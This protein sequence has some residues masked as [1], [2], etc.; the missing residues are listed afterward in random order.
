MSFPIRLLGILIALLIAVPTTVGQP[1]RNLDQAIDVQRNVK[2][3]YQELIAAMHQVARDLEDKDPDTAAAIATAADKAE[4]A[5][6]A[7]DMEKVITLLESGLVLP[8]DATQAKVITQLREV[9]DVLRRGGDDLAARFFELEQ[10]RQQIEALEQLLQQQRLLERK[11][12]AVAFGGDMLKNIA[13][14]RSNVN[15][16]VAAVDKTVRQ[17]TD[18]E[19][20]PVAEQLAGVGDMLRALQRQLTAVQKS[21][22]N[23]FPS[24]DEMAG[25]IVMLKHAFREATRVRTAIRTVTNRDATAASL[26]DAGGTSHAAQV[27][28]HVDHVADELQRAAEALEADKLENGQVAVAEA[29]THLQDASAAHLEV[30]RSLG[31]SRSMV[32]AIERLQAMQKQIET[33]AAQVQTIAP[34]DAVEDDA[35]AGV[36]T[37]HEE[38]VAADTRLDQQP[39]ELALAEA[40]LAALQR[41]DRLAAAAEMRR[42]SAGM[43]AWRDRLDDVEQQVAD[44]R[45]T[46]RFDEQQAEQS[47]IVSGIG[48]IVDKAATGGAD[49][50]TMPN[51]IALKL[52][53]AKHKADEAATRLG[54]KEAAEANGRQNE[55][56]AILAD[57]TAQMESLFDSQVPQLNEDVR[58]QYLA[59]LERC[60]LLQ[61]QVI[62]ET[63]SIW[64]Q[65]VDDDGKYRRPQLLKLIAVARLQGRMHEYFRELES[66][67][68]VAESGHQLVT[69]PMIVPMLMDLVRTDTDRV[70]ARLEARDAG[71]RTQ[72]MQQQMLERLEAMRDAMSPGGDEQGMSPPPRFADNS[73]GSVDVSTTNI[74]AEIQMLMA[75]QGQ[76]LDRTEQL[77]EDRKT[78]RID[79]ADYKTQLDELTRQQQRVAWMIRNIMLGTSV[80]WRPGNEEAPQ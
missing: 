38:H 31:S 50:A 21:V 63:L 28:N 36:N 14:L 75:L 11:S 70:K 23:P 5:F 4:Q 60:I 61:K 68:A 20:D 13:D 16:L 53:D 27:V 29:V 25:N 43:D 41:F 44:I 7:D 57:V 35:D 65:R 54:D 79:A 9:L 69:W 72:T 17:F 18:H 76:I 47:E 34:L 77:H 51:D 56:I 22:A 58:E 78:D 10:L 30:M 19:L 33:L 49:G 24:P 55:V 74:I 80:R 46:P 52:V 39:K 67:M 40:A 32:E 8:A 48:Q 42:L 12:R 15:Q 1:A 62:A 45:K 37:I 64:E 73:F 71:P 2:K 6:I 66:L 26:K 59:A 3:R